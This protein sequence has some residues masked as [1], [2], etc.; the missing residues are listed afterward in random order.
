MIELRSNICVTSINVDGPNILL[1]QLDQ[2][3]KSI[4]CCGQEISDPSDG[5]VAIGF[6]S[7]TSGKAEF[8]P[9]VPEFFTGE[10]VEIFW[11]REWISGISRTRKQ[12]NLIFTG[13]VSSRFLIIIHWDREYCRD[14][15]FEKKD[16]PF[17][18]HLLY[19]VG[20]WSRCAGHIVS[21]SI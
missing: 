3:A 7:A 21:M 6:E 13:W 10:M 12:K 5:F 1:N 17:I 11:D 19:W 20:C 2:D 15:G 14:E 18:L 8:R 16:G 4:I 9:K